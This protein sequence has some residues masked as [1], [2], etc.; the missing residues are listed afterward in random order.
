MSVELPWFR[1]LFEE[2]LQYRR[3]TLF[4]DVLTP[5]IDK[6]QP[7]FDDFGRFKRFSRFDR[8]DHD[9][10]FTMWNL[11]A[12]SRVNDVLLTAIQDE[13]KK[14]YTDAKLPLTEY[15]EFFQRCGFSVIEPDRFSPFYHEI[16]RVHQSDDDQEPIEV[17]RPVW[18][19][20]MF[21][22]LLFSRSGVEVK[23]GRKNV[24]KEIA[25]RSTLYFAYRRFDRKTTDLSMGWGSNSQWR[26]QI[27]RDYLTEGKYVYNADGKNLLNS[28]SAAEPDRDGLTPEQR[29]ELCCNRCFIVTT[30]EDSDLWP[31]DDRFEKPADHDERKKS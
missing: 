7:A 31:Y 17:L 20:L 18:P 21:G 29:S 23:G 3:H 9:S 25:E 14:C 30:K 6:G 16:V 27:R 2:I 12:L 22:D 15:A 10:Q 24:I 26:T 4:H 19:V 8:G 13:S 1:Q 28:P 11:Y 5:W